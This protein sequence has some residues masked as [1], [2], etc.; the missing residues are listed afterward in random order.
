MDKHRLEGF[1]DAVIAVIATLMVIE[2]RPPEGT[3]LHELLAVWPTFFAFFVSFALIY[4]VWRNHHDLFQQVET[5]TADVFYMNGLWLFLLSLVPFS[6][7]WVGNHP[8]D[9]LPEFIY[10]FVML[11]WS[12][13]YM[14]LARA[15]KRANPHV[16]VPTNLRAYD[17]VTN[18]N[19]MISILMFIFMLLTFVLP[20]AGLIG[21]LLISTLNVIIAYRDA[22]RRKF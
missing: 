14:L 22:A 3:K 2:L 16:K 7:D 21:V 15:I 12:F 9:T 17:V 18:G 10:V 6:T 8:T 4:I 5:V 20:I 11:V 19:G 1:T 13:S